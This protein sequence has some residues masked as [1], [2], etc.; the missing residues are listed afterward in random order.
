[1]PRPTRFCRFYIASLVIAICCP[2]AH[3]QGPLLPGAGPISRSMGGASTAAPLDATGTL[4]WNPAAISGLPSSELDLGLEL[5]NPRSTISSSIPGGALGPGFPPAS[6]S[7]RSHDDA[8]VFALPS[9]GFVYKP[10][11]SRWTFGLGLFPTAGFG[12]NFAGSSTNP[13]LSPPPPLGLGLG[14]VSSEYELLQIAPTVS[15]QLTDR[16][17]VGFA[18]LIDV[19]QLDVTPGVFFSPDAGQYP[20]A[21]SSRTAWGGGFQAGVYYVAS[22]AWRLGASFKSPQWFEPFHYQSA[23]QF[24]RPVTGSFNLNAPLIASIGAAYTGVDRLTIDADIRYVDF[25]NTLGVAATGFDSTGAV[26]GL[27]WNDAFVFA[28]GAQYQLTDNF[29]I[30][31]GYTYNTNPIPDQNATFNVASPLVY[32]HQIAVG[33]SYHLGPNCVLSLTYCHIFE[34]S[35]T[36]PYLTPQGP[37]PGA[38]VSIGTQ[39]DS[40]VFGFSVR[41]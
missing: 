34:S 36:G 39:A 9:G 3:A 16:L 32:Q 35:I 26:R 40:L 41:F 15:Y 2:A 28:L 23:D 13:I 29:S 18:P 20:V 6:A 33:A 25:R 17:S 1:M 38:T 24:G 22:D 5:L 21:T 12:T 30:R 8:G 31:A 7:G 37:I 11:E 14:H 4:Y 10:E 19:A 27:G